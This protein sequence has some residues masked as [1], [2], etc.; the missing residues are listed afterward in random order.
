MGLV[1]AEIFMKQSKNLSVFE[2]KTPLCLR[3]FV[4]E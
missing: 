3:A 1:I 4:R 2:I